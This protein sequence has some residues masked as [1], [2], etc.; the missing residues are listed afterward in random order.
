MCPP[1]IA[2]TPLVGSSTRKDPHARIPTRSYFET[3]NTT[4]IHLCASAEQLIRMANVSKTRVT[5]RTHHRTDAS[6]PSH[7]R[8]RRHLRDEAS[9]N[10]HCRRT[11]RWSATP[12][13]PG[14][15]YAPPLTLVALSAGERE[16]QDQKTESRR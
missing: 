11:R 7:L 14:W 3:S 13:H 1:E 6:L 4:R 9:A 5:I 2:R 8:V 10:Q 15:V 16:R 12:R